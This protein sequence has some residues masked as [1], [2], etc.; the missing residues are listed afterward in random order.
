MQNEDEN[1]HGTHCAGTAAG[2]TTGVCRQATV[3]NVKVLGKD[4]RGSYSGIIAG[5]QWAAND[6]IARGAVTKSVISVSLGGGYSDSLNAAVQGVINQGIPV[7]VAA[8]NANE[9]V[10]NTSPASAPNA[11]TVG[12]IDSTD[13]RAWFSNFGPIVDIF[14][15][16]V[17]IYSAWAG[18]DKDY[19]WLDGTSQATPHVAGLAAYYMIKEKAVGAKAVLDKIVSKSV[20]N[21]VKDPANSPNRIAYNNNGQ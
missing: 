15:P 17:N 21:L 6:A 7:V 4:G 5:M 11:I 13:T 20:K 9:N 14:A 10:I 2:W 16:G 3:V 19:A 18:S 1:G 8:G 12:A